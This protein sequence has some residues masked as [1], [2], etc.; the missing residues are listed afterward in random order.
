MKFFEYLAAGLPIVSTPLDAIRDYTSLYSVAGD[1]AAFVQA[2]RLILE[3]K[4]APLP[5]NDP[6]LLQNCWETRMDRM[7]D[8][9]D[10][11]GQR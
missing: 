2:I 5:T 8:I 11:E 3:R 10:P 7:L 1:A 9:I 4:P 6:I